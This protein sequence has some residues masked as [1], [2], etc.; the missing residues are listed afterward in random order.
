MYTEE[1][2]WRVSEG[3]QHTDGFSSGDRKASRALECETN[4][5][6]SVSASAIGPKPVDIVTATSGLS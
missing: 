4:P 1:K 3:L 6:R 2:M 5:A